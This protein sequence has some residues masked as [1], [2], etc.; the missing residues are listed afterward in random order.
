MAEC[1]R[2]ERAIAAAGGI[3]L[4]ILGIGTNGHIGFNEPAPALQARTHRVTLEA[5]DAAR[6]RRALRRRSG[7]GAARSA[8]DGDGDDPAGAADR[9]RRD[10]DGRRRRC[11]ERLV[12]GPVTTELPASFL[13]LH[14]DVEVMLDAAAAAGLERQSLIRLQQLAQ[15]RLDVLADRLAHRVVRLLQ[16]LA[17]PAAA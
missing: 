6:Q 7:G 13:Q 12:S 2:Y 4:Q 14:P 5:R 9:A 8:V 3:D 1:A 16:P 10:G 15:A 17:A 11:V